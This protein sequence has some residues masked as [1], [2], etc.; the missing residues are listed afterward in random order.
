[1][2]S[3][4]NLNF[5]KARELILEHFDDEIWKAVKVAVGV[6]ASLSLKGRDNCLFVVVVGTSGKGKSIVM[7]L[8]MPDREVSKKRVIRIDEF[9]AASFVSHAANRTEDELEEIDLLPRLKDKLMITKELAPLFGEDEKVLR[10]IFAIITSV[11]D[12][13]G[14]TR[15]SGTQGSRGY[16]GKY[17]FN[18]L[19]ATTHSFDQETRY[20]PLENSLKDATTLRV[21]TPPNGNIAPP[22]YYMLFIMKDRNPPGDARNHIHATPPT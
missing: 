7:R 17:L 10:K 15:E 20:L 12:G 13:N 1:M 8:L 4:K 2:K 5:D 9:S 21:V 6:A 18:W 19:G 11:L 16:T 22:R 3:N 14:Y